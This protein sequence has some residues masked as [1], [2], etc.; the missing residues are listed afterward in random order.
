MSLTPV[1]G[2]Q[3]QLDPGDTQSVELKK[4]ALCSTK[5]TVSINE[6]ERWRRMSG[7]S[8]CTS[9][10]NTKKTTTMEAAA[11]AAVKT[12]KWQKTSRYQ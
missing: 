11:A 8:V 7:I 6:V 4:E 2:R 3:R 1:L 9:T 10:P 12:T 5:E